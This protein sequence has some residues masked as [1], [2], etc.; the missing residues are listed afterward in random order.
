[1]VVM[2]ALVGVYVL[3]LAIGAALR[4]SMG[5]TSLFALGAAFPAAPFFGPAI[6]GALFGPKSAVAIAS[7]AIWANLLLVPLSVVLLETGQRAARLNLHLLV[8]A[9]T[10]PNQP[11]RSKVIPGGCRSEQLSAIASCRR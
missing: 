1:M 6:L 7:T 10:P 8:R 3:A 4:L 11:K 2:I 5:A 9:A